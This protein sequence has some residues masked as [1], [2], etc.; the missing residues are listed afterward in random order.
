MP[1]FASSLKSEISRLARKE[2]KGT[3]GALRAAINAHRSDIAALKRRVGELERLLKGLVK[4]K[5]AAPL[6]GT[7][8]G[9]TTI[10]TRFSA[11]GF[12]A[13]RKRL[14]LS[15]HDV[16][17]LLGASGQTVYN[18]ETGKARPRDANMPA[19]AALRKLGRRQA[20][21]VVSERR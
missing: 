12:A 7:T 16:G 1:N 9:S 20:Q 2:M 8:E 5:T 4:S 18:W 19:I 15:A 10:K 11:K 3:I 13:Q 17:L 14:S 21:A 6:N